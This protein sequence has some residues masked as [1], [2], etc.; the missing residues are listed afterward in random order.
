M[1]SA[2]IAMDWTHCRRPV[3]ELFPEWA[4]RCH[5]IRDKTIR[6]W[7]AESG[8]VVVGASNGA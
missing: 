5:W 6:I 4:P 2:A 3:R 7:D 1:A 8:A